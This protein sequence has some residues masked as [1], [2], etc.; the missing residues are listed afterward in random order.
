ML[1]NKKAINIILI[2][3]ETVAG[4]SSPESRHAFWKKDSGTSARLDSGSML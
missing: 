3:L 4:Q 2:I 1:N